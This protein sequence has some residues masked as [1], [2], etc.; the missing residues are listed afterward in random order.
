[1]GFFD[2]FT[3]FVGEIKSLKSEMT[4]IKDGVANELQTSAQ[5]VS[6]TVTDTASTLKDSADD[7][8]ATIQDTAALPSSSFGSDKF[9]G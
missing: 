5:E 2:E 4:D 1:M 6:Q 3:D 7:I 8:K 9:N